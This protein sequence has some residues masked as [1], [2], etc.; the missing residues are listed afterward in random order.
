VSRGGERWLDEQAGRLVRP[1][2]LT[3]GRSAPVGHRFDLLAIVRT[4]PGAIRQTRDLEPAHLLILEYTR[5]PAAIIDLA[6]H[7][8]LP[9]GVV[10]V[11]LSDLA[12]QSLVTIHDPPRAPH[13][14]LR[15]LQDV[16]DGLRRL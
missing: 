4:L 6:S 5:S 7:F 3:G 13:T 16:L 9:A 12:E 11:L 8:D 1:Y 14:D 10:R 2:A 15:L